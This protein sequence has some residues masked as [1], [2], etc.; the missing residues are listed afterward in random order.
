MLDANKSP[1][2]ILYQESFTARLFYTG[3]SMLGNMVFTATGSAIT[4][5]IYD[6][7]STGGTKI[8][9]VQCPA[10][11]TVIVPGD[12]AIETGIY[13]TCGTSAAL[14]TIALQYRPRAA[15]E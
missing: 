3:R 2:Y 9:K 10:G 4:Y 13:V 5:I 12:Y 6:G 1:T 15:Q 8:M 7:T 11:E 14:N